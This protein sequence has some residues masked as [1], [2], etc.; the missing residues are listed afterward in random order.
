MPDI[1]SDMGRDQQLGK[2]TR[3]SP[4]LLDTSQ[5]HGRLVLGAHRAAQ[6]KCRSEER[7]VLLNH[8]S[9]LDNLEREEHKNFL[10]KGKIDFVFS[11]RYQE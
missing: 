8:S 10:G 7:G 9:M 5:T 4:K 1:T 6:L 2:G 3:A 11:E